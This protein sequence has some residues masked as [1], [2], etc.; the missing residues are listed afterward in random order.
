M[1]HC[2]RTKGCGCNQCWCN[3]FVPI[4]KEHHSVAQGSDYWTSGGS[5]PVD[6][7]MTVEN[8]IDMVESMWRLKHMIS[9]PSQLPTYP[10]QGTLIT[11]D[12]FNRCVR[13]AKQL[14]KESDDKL[15]T[16]RGNNII[17]PHWKAPVP[18]EKNVGDYVHH[19]D[20]S[21][22]QLYVSEHT[23]FCKCDC[24]YCSCDNMTWQGS[25]AVRG[26]RAI[27]KKP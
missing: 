13:I 2:H 27:F 16:A 7:V 26:G 3:G 21:N 5:Y 23:Y 12:W 8:A 15:A 20:F 11:A 25:G 10:S 9:S 22:I 19:N 4:N 14:A 18:I 6:N 17:S 24:D 1:G